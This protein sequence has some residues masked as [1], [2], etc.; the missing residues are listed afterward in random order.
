MFDNFIISP[1][2]VN[3]SI[4]NLYS[5]FL[6]SM[7]QKSYLIAGES[8]NYIPLVSKVTVIEDTIEQKEQNDYRNTRSN[9]YASHCK[10]KKEKMIYF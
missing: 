4:F 6:K 9:T 1:S 10:Y 7:P 8:T 3:T 2:A 5:T